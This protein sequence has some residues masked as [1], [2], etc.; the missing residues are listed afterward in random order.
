ML[1][2]VLLPLWPP[3][4]LAFFATPNPY[5]ALHSGRVGFDASV[6]SDALAINQAL[7]ISCALA[8]AWL[9]RA[10]PVLR[11]PLVLCIGFVSLLLSG[12]WNGTLFDKPHSYAY[13]MGSFLLVSTLALAPHRSENLKTLYWLSC[14]AILLALL[15]AFLQPSRW[16]APNFAF[17]RIDRGEL[18][19]AAYLGCYLLFPALTFVARD[20][21]L[22]FRLA[23][24]SVISFLTIAMFSRTPIYLFVMPALTYGLCAIRSRLLFCLLSAGLVAFATIS[25]IWFA[26]NVDMD[27]LLTGRLELWLFHLKQFAESPLL[28]GGAFLA[29]RSSDY[30]GAAE[31][32][33]GVL[34]SFAEHGIVWGGTQLWVVATACISALRWLRSKEDPSMSMYGLVV[35]TA[36]PLFLLEGFSRILSASEA[37]FWLCAFRLYAQ[38]K[39][40]ESLR[41]HD[42]PADRPAYRFAP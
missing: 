26:E 3:L 40:P 30:M 14:L 41:T 8:M 29:T 39:I 18:P 24:W 10:Q 36:T 6:T 20:I 19:L 15:A 5:A 35:L 16:G 25:L 9:I 11:A 22:W 31:S 32:E 28:G 27:L 37:I 13:D 33:V 21:P 2:N 42:L 7:L 23:A 4:L 34:K 1:R 38:R 17:S 12:V